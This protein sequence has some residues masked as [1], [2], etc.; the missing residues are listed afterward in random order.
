MKV[1]NFYTQ[2]GVMCACTHAAY[3]ESAAFPAPFLRKLKIS[4][5]YGHSRTHF[6][7]QI[8]LELY[9]TGQNFSYGL[10][11]NMAVTAPMFKFLIMQCH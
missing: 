7:F 8:L 5:F 3:T 11:Y 2:Y 1:F 6:L 4:Q 10:Q 9:K